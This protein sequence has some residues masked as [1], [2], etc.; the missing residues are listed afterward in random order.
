M[1][2]TVPVSAKS[3]LPGL[4][5]PRRDQARAQALLG[6]FEVGMGVRA[7]EIEAREGPIAVNADARCMPLRLLARL[8]M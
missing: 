2:K 8:A 4:R 1:R 7:P 5:T 6:F 3:S